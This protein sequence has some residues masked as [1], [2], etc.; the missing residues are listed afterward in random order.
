MD[1]IEDP[2][3]LTGRGQ[4]LED[5][6]PPDG[7]W[8]AFVRSPHAHAR[9]LRIETASALEV[10]G[11][12]GVFTHR[13]LDAAGIRD[14]PCLGGAAIAHETAMSGPL[15]PTLARNTVR[16]V[17]EAVA[18]VVARCKWSALDGAERVEVDYEPLD[19]LPSM[20]D[21]EFTV[22]AGLGQAAFRWTSGVEKLT[23]AAF[24]AAH[25]IAAIRVRNTRVI[26]APLEPRGIIARPLCGRRGIEATISGQGVHGLRNVLSEGVL[27]WAADQLRIRTRDVGGGFGAKIPVYP[28]YVAVIHAARVLKAPVT[29]VSTRTE[30]FEA[31]THGRAHISHAELALD[32]DGRMLGLRIRTAADLGAYLSQTGPKLSTLNYAPVLTNTY[33]VPA[34]Y[35]E[36]VGYLSNRSPVDAYRG[37]GRPEAIY[38]IERLVD[39]AAHRLHLCAADIRR[40]N[41]LTS[42]RL[43]HASVLGCRF[44]DVDFLRLLDAA[45]ERADWGGF[46]TRRRET[47]AAGRLRGRGMAMFIQDIGRDG[48]ETARLSYDAGALKL[49]LDVGNQS[50]G[51]GHETTF[52]RMLAK[53]LGIPLERIRVRQGDSAALPSGSGTGNSRAMTVGGSA[54]ATTATEFIRMSRGAAA[55]A[56]EAD[57]ADIS[58]SEGRFGVVGTDRAIDLLSLLERAHRTRPDHDCLN[59]LGHF[60]H[61]HATYASGCHIAEVEIDR[62]TWGVQ[63]V[64]YIC[65]NDFG[66]VLEPEVVAGQVHG[67]V[68]QGVGQAMSERII[69]DQTSGQLATASF[70]DYAIPR[71]EE[72][73]NIMQHTLPMRASSNPLGVRG[74]GESGTIAAP[75]AIVNAVLDALRPLGVEDIQ[76]PITSQ[77]IW[78]AVRKA[79]IGAC[80][81]GDS[82]GA[83]P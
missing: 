39:E 14:L 79:E 52:A 10:A 75:P 19:V 33:D 32:N 59:V 23:D 18:L 47:E 38:L 1:R 46:A 44:T 31:D 74:C 9:I 53:R 67:G 41:L 77:E 72:A 40:K 26:A 69:Y 27:G 45:Q 11:V 64:R 56:L 37:A 76:M 78:R 58:F 3:F 15:R 2:R 71:A 6:A 43:P 51:Q 62:D 20:D 5:L 73:P 8:A 57:E 81:P 83:R 35:V 66:E 50:N 7:L 16:F 42:A 80:L 29:W 17:G 24:A 30:S 36:V 82:S 54:I 49:V 48:S 70:L 63:L 55:E 34:A 25:A 60:A 21:D 28:E 61:P 12:Q 4:F 22:P 13:E 68:A 65:V